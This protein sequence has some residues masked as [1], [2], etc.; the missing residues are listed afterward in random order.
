VIR[1]K[2]VSIAGLMGIVLI[3]SFGLAVMRQATPVLAG[4]MSL[5]TCG[6]LA[7]AVVGVVCRKA[8]RAWWLG[9]ALFGWGY[10]ALVYWP[11][12]FIPGPPTMTIL[13][14]FMGKPEVPVTPASP[15]FTIDGPSY[16]IPPSRNVGH[17]LWSLLVAALGGALAHAFF[18][19]GVNRSEDDEAVPPAP[20][21]IPWRRWLRSSAIAVVGLFLA[22]TGALFAL[23][24]APVFWVGAM[25]VLT[26]GV[27]GVAILGAA[28][29]RGN[30]RTCWLGAALFGAGYMTLVVG[31]DP[32]ES[33][34]PRR[35][36]EDSL[37]ALCPLLPPTE[38]AYPPS[39]P[40]VAI[41]N[42]RIR[43][44][45]EQPVALHFP[46]D[47]PLGDVLGFI[48][49][50]AR[51]ADGS[52]LPIYVDPVGLQEAEKTMQSPVR[53]DMEGVPLKTG[54]QLTLRQ[55]GMIY[56]IREGLLEINSTAECSMPYIEDP[57]LSVG[58][59][60]LALIAAGVGSLVAPL[61][62]GPQ[63]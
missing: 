2:R 60:L 16:R 19:T 6:V 36:I 52:R 39:S 37:R 42:A 61:V 5:A 43:R 31:T 54:L 45:L 14:A 25:F 20:A 7:L 1:T 51:C 38:R 4:L 33:P 35:A 15:M 55:L 32:H 17:C 40:E 27:I 3:V 63:Q 13:E 30:R 49:A 23:R 56:E 41:A 8:E 44:A 10:L 22:V 12:L 53:I 34:W 58:H 11:S 26:W 57:L 46:E 62:A 29:N 18:G 47:T 50:T 9:F 48:A 59:C 28:S 24:W 21:R